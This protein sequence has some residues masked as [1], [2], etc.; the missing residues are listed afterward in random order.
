MLTVPFLFEL[1]IET[2]AIALAHCFEV[3]LTSFQKL[4]TSPW[5][6]VGRCL[7]TERT[8]TRSVFAGWL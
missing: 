6:R 7:R 8:V 2:N 1:Q 3:Y 4:L 5:F